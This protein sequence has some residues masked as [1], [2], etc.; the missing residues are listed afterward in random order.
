MTI[1]EDN[2]RKMKQIS[3]I[4]DC[5]TGVGSRIKGHR[6][7]G[8]KW[9]QETQGENTYKCITDEAYTTQMCLFCF[10]KLN[11]PTYQVCCNGLGISIFERVFK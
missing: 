1:D 4:G 2:R 10:S 11:Y 8:G 6:R 9:K 5:R 7:Y 3:F